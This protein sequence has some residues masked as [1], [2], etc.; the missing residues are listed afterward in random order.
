MRT[1]HEIVAGGGG[2]PHRYYI[3]VKAA[4]F[5]ALAVCWSGFWVVGFDRAVHFIMSD[6]VVGCAVLLY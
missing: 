6:G 5:L 2:Q 1:S 4:S 3:H